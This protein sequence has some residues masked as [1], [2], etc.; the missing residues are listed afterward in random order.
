MKR[1]SKLVIVIVITTLCAAASA[2]AQVKPN[3]PDL[4]ALAAKGKPS[5]KRAP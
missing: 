1:M 4:N 5:P 2:P 3:P